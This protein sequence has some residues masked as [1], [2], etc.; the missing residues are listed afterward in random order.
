[1]SK[2]QTGNMLGSWAFLIGVILALVFGLFGNLSP[3]I[4]YVLVVLGIIIGLLNIAAKE[5]MPFLMAGTV[6]VI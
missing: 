5:A 4:T 3:A 1:M 2:K 6:L